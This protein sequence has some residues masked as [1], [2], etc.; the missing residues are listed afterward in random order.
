MNKKE[1]TKRKLR[2]KNINSTIF[3]MNNKKQKE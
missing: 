1:F 3:A 2:L